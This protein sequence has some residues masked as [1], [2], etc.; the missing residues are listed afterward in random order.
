MADDPTAD[1][2]SMARAAAFMYASAASLSLI[3]VVPPN[4]PRVNE[5]GIV[6]TALAAYAAVAL[7]L[8]VFDRLP[9]WAFYVLVVVSISLVTLAIYFDGHSESSYAL[10]Y[11]WVTIYVFYFFSWAPAIAVML[12]V[13]GAYAGVISIRETVAAGE[14][15]LLTVGTL[16]LLGALIGLLRR[17]M[18]GLVSR[19]ADAASTDPLTELLNRRAFE[20]AFD[21][22]L[23]RARR[24]SRR[25]ALVVADLDH[26]KDV[27]DRLGHSRGD[28]VLVRTSGVLETGKRRIDTLARIGGEEFAL[29]MPDSTESEAL[30]ATERLRNLVREALAAEDVAVTMSFG[31]ANYPDQGQ[32][33][34][35]LLHAADRALYAAKELGRDRAVIYS[36]EV[37]DI[38]TGSASWRLSHG[39]GHLATVISLAEALD[40]RDMGTRGHSQMAG[41]YAEAIARELGLTPERVERVRLAGVLHDVGK[42]GVPDAILHKAGPLDEEEWEDMRKH[43]VIGSRLVGGSELEDICAWILAHHERPDGRGFPKGL[44][45]DEIPLEAKIIAVADAWEAM[46]SDRVYRPALSEEAARTELMRCAGTGFDERVVEALLAIRDRATRSVAVG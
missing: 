7:F 38:L 29:L 8:V 17:R 24:G 43:P 33:A 25:L 26:F 10:F 19:L 46:T 1:R 34:D 42:I 27:N 23:E 11:L 4:E 12:L 21:S 3:A 20:A 32:T 16:L 13:G 45:A 35:E 41:R 9:I 30:V 15:W 37:D 18:Q 44:S 31:I 14:R 40:V 5:L 36:A 28:E 22:E 6:L 39:Q 2:A